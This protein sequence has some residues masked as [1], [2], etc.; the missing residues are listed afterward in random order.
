LPDARGGSQYYRTATSSAMAK[1]VPS[2]FLQLLEL[3]SIDFSH[4][5]AV[6]AHQ[7]ET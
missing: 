7:L 1:A 6:D 4:L 2:N 3:Q 5:I